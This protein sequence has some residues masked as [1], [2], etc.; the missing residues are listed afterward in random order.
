MINPNPNP[1]QVVPC[2]LGYDLVAG[3]REEDRGGGA[4]A[5]VLGRAGVVVALEALT[6]GLVDTL[7][8]WMD[9]WMDG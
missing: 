3:H 7:G 6:V 2:R 8:R 9:G 4:V 1:N 5:S